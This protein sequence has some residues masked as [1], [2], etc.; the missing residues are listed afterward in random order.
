MRKLV[1]LMLVF[2]F[3]PVNAGDFK[4]ITHT[5]EIKDGEEYFFLYGTS[6]GNYLVKSWQFDLK[7]NWDGNGE[8]N[9][10][11]G[12]AVAK[13]YDYFNKSKQELGIKEVSFRPAFSK[14]GSTVWFYHVE[15]TTLPYKFGADTSEAVILTS[16]EIVLPYKPKF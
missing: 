9:L 7:N 15:L 12:M 16:G 6:A 2:F 1:F 5:K 11:I 8:P 3:L 4:L 13:T 14:Q 10:S